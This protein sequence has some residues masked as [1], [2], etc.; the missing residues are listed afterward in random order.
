MTVDISPACGI[1][2][3]MYLDGIDILSHDRDKVGQEH[4]APKDLLKELSLPEA[5]STWVRWLEAIIDTLGWS[6]SILHGKIQEVLEFRTHAQCQ[7]KVYNLSMV[8]YYTPV[9]VLLIAWLLEAKACKGKYLNV[10][11]DMRADLRLF[12]ENITELKAIRNIS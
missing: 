4:P 12:R 3:L 9:N 7:R 6:L 11:P 5:M 10:N 1:Q 2:T 8:N